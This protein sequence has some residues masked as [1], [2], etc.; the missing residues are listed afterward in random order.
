MVLKETASSFITKY[1]NGRRIS[2]S[3]MQKT[4]SPIF[5]KLVVSG[6]ASLENKLK[7]IE[8]VP[9]PTTHTHTPNS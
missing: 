9:L 2:Y 7:L 1:F 8:F 4:V 6:H 5:W 3:Y